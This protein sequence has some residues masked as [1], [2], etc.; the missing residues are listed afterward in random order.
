MQH[1]MWQT[2]AVF[3]ARPLQTLT[4]RLADKS[5]HDKSPL[6]ES[7]L[8]YVCFKNRIEIDLLSRFYFTFFFDTIDNWSKISVCMYLAETCLDL[9]LLW[10]VILKQQ[11]VA[12]ASN[13]K[14]PASA[15]GNAQ[16]RCIFESPVR[17]K[18]SSPIL[19]KAPVIYNVLL[20]LVSRRDMSRSANAVSS[21]RRKFSLPFCYLAPSLGVIPFEFTEKLYGSY[22]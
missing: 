3:V 17:Q 7:V 14:S 5:T 12:A 18:L 19:T 16:Q 1:L 8:Q 6:L 21:G 9:L 4:A 22:K 2:P 15:K 13:R 20:V 10:L 11:H